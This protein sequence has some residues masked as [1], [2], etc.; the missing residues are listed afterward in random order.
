MNDLF[1]VSTEYKTHVQNKGW[2]EPVKNGVVSGTTG[3]SLQ[4]EAFTCNLILPEGLDLNVMCR[5]HVAQRGWLDPVYNGGVCG[6][7][8]QGLALQAVQ[9]EL[10]GRDAV[11]FD[12]WVQLH[13]SGKGWMNW[14]RGGELC[15]TVGLDLRAEAIK[16][17]VFDR[18][19]S[20]KTDGVEGFVEY[21]APPAVV[22][23]PQNLMFSEHFSRSEIGCDCLPE[24]YNFG[25]CDGYPYP[26][27]M[28]RNLKNLLNVLEAIR[29]Y[30]GTP[31]IIT[32]LIRC[33][34]ANDYWGGIPGSYHTTY[35][36][37][38][39]VVP[40]HSPYEVACVA[41]ELTGCGA[42]YYRDDG[43][44]H[45]EPAGCGVYCQQ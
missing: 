5:A 20:L 36:A 28:A 35:Q 22:P 31:V 30:F 21:V 9:L 45:I 44:T 38:D 17:I 32:S 10:T 11:N 29:N 42:R 23:T 8:G 14:M 12:I 4:M 13:V 7:V 16:I 15:G 26:E 25:W 27:Q 37:A 43:F 24:K 34:Q 33:E 18:R 1:I 40:G 3:E 39:I 19:I 6:T 2:L 41:N